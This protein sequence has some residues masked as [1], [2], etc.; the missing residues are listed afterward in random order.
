MEEKTPATHRIPK[1]WVHAAERTEKVG[2]EE[3]E[4]RLEPHEERA[5]K[6]GHM[7]KKTVQ[8]VEFLT[9]HA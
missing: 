1:S 8:V 3:K 9:N 5:G 2:G 7:G 6:H 4:Y